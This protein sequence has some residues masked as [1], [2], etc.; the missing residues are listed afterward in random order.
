MNER[1]S[2]QVTD[3]KELAHVIKETSKAKVCKVRHQTGDRGKN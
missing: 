3:F 1:V 2:R